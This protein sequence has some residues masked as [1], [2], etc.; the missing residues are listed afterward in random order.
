MRYPECISHTLLLVHQPTHPAAQRTSACR[1]PPGPHPGCEVH[2]QEQGN[3]EIP[4]L[5]DQAKY[6]PSSFGS[7]I[8]ANDEEIVVTSMSLIQ[9]VKMANFWLGIRATGVTTGLRRIPAG[10]YAAVQHD[11]L[12][13]RT[14]NKPVLVNN[15]VVQWDGQIPM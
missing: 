13:W 3:D 2:T 6:V 5:E 11:G 4:G 9:L 14:T 1:P 7:A 8:H 12:E 10:F 15:D